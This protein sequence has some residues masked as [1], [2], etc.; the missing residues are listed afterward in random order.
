MEYLNTT[1]SNIIQFQGNKIF[2]DY[3]QAK[4]YQVLTKSLEKSMDVSPLVDFLNDNSEVYSNPN[5]NSKIIVAD[6]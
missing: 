3:T 2:V 6:D 1:Q 4:P 5:T